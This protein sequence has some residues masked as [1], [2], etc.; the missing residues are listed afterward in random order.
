VDETEWL[1]AIPGE[2]KEVLRSGTWSTIRY[3]RKKGKKVLII[4][5]DGSSIVEK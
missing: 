5:P 3:A 4:W 1:W 2:F